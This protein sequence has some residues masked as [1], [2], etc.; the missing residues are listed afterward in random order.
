MTQE[1]NL[2]RMIAR[3]PDDAPR[4]V[5]ADWLEDHGLDD[6]AEFIRA[7]VRL[8]HM[9]EDSRE[10]RELAFRCRQLI[11]AHENEWFDRKSGQVT[12]T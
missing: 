3:E 8:S 11:E 5:Y 4:L 9:R 6:R 7:Q 1:R 12:D 2:L 10:R